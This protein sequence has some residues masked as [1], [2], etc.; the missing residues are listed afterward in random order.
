MPQNHYRS[1]SRPVFFR[2]KRSSRR[3]LNPQ[4]RKKPGVSIACFNALRFTLA[5][6]IK[7]L[8]IACE[9]AHLREA[10]VLPLPVGVIARRQT[11]FGN[12]RQ[13]AVCDLH[14][15]FGLRVGKRTEQ[16]ILHHAEDRRICANAQRQSQHRH[17]REP[18][19]LRQRA[20]AVADVLHQVFHESLLGRQFRERFR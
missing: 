7:P 19:I 1:T 9:G 12:L 11:R 18:G 13:I 10:L 2:K 6:K 3:R 15:T 8:G 14:Q 20:N 17:N 5:R 16:Q 4:H